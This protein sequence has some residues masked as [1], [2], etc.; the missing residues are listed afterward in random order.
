[1]IRR[2]LTSARRLAA[3]AAIDLITRRAAV[4][5]LEHRLAELERR[6][7]ELDAGAD[8]DGEVVS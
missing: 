6:V 7:A 8:V 2:L 5:R 4:L 1:M 3:H